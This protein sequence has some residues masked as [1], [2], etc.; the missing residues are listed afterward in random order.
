MQDAAKDYSKFTHTNET[1]A[2]L[3]CLLCHKREANSTRPEMPG[4]N[5][6]LPCIGCHTQQFAD[7]GSPICTICHTDVATG[8]VKAFPSLK[9][10][11]MR[12]NHAPHV[13]QT[14]AACAACHKPSG[15]GVAL[16]IPAGS[17]AHATCFQCH[18]AGA[19]N[20]AGRDI[21]SCSTCHQLGGYRRTTEWAAA[22]KV[23]FSHARH[24]PRQKLNCS[25]CHSV[26]AGAA[27]GRQVAKPLPLN[28]HAPPRAQS[29]MT[30]HNG[31]RAFGGDDFSSC[32]RCH[33]GAHF[34]F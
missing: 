27:Q 25:D 26:Q 14:G 21:S 2:Q 7:S 18:S 10:F 3:P 19:K 4:R 24:T 17:G 23:S 32:K 22:Y 11:N 5:G 33:Q 16:S 9:S 1:H 13:R 28:H 31:K 6:H 34:Y 29:C 12:F 15:R 20:S 8:A 30:C